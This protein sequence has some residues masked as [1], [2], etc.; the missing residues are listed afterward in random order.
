[1]MKNSPA[2]ALHAVILHNGKMFNS[3]PKGTIAVRKDFAYPF[4]I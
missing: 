4:L 1:M 3:G 2:L